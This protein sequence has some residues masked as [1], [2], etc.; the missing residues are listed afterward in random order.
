MAE[1][2]LEAAVCNLRFAR[3]L[4]EKLILQ[5]IQKTPVIFTA[6]EHV[7]T[8]GFG[9]KVMEFLERNNIR[10]IQLKRFALPDEFIEQGSREKLLDHFG[11]SGEK[12]AKAIGEALK[13]ASNLGQRLPT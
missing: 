5:V 13:F 12:M 3:P 4:D 11:L 8:G 9:S 10:D 7:L 6:E 2:G 1:E